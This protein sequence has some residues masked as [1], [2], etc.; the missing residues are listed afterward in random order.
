MGG[1]AAI[2]VRT[3]EEKAGILAG[4]VA[5]GGVVL[6]LLLVQ[7]GV[8]RARSPE[9]VARRAPETTVT[10]AVPSRG[11][12]RAARARRAL[13]ALAPGLS[14]TGSAFGAFVAMGLTAISFPT[15]LRLPRWIE[16][17][18]VLVAWWGM[19][20]VALTTLLY[21]GYRYEDDHFFHAPDAR[22]AGRSLREAIEATGCG[23][24]GCDAGC[25]DSGEGILVGIAFLFVAALLLLLS[26]FV[27]FVIAELALP[28]VFL[29]FYALTRSAI[30][31]AARDRHDCKGRLVVS[32]AWG[33][34]WS[35]AYL[36]PLAT[37]VWI[38]HRALQ[39]AS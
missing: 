13:A 11:Q 12:V 36:A 15:L 1:G 3:H 29:A 27:A 39:D 24:P 20:V 37:V 4:A 19:A 8:K 26:L 31:R 16:A 28:L 34:L 7:A 14:G 23:D 9:Q 2:W 33:T 6:G 10:S 17:E 38:V 32:L 21:R 30:R 22:K 35:T 5:L 25:S 18:I